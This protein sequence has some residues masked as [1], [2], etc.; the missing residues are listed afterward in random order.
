MHPFL[1]NFLK[2]FYYYAF[3][4]LTRNNLT[5]SFGI[6]KGLS[7]AM[8]FL[9]ISEASFDA[10]SQNK[11][12]H[13][14]T[15]DSQKA[16]DVVSHPILLDK[17]YHTGVNFKVWSPVKGMYKGL[18]SRVKA[19]VTILADFG[20]EFNPPFRWRSKNQTKKSQCISLTWSILSFQ[21]GPVE[22]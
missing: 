11:P 22:V 14:V 8:A 1:E 4:Q 13:V 17:L 20:P 16:F 10:K 12:L 2:H 19:S 9:L 7:P 5:F 3:L 18:S 6:T 15:L 21:T